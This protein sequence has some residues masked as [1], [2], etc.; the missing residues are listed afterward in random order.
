MYERILPLAAVLPMLD[1]AHL[2]HVEPI[3]R[4]DRE[5]SSGELLNM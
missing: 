3:D 5:G 4:Q 2:S 1:Q